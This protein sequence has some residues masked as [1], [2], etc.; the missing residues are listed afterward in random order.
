MK[1]GLVRSGVFE[2]WRIINMSIDKRGT[3]EK[4]TL[5]SLTGSEIFGYTRL[6]CHELGEHLIL[7]PHSFSFS[8]SKIHSHQR[9]SRNW[10]HLV[11][12]ILSS[13][14][15]AIC[16]NSK[17]DDE[18]VGVRREHVLTRNHWRSVEHSNFGFYSLCFVVLRIGLDDFVEKI[19]TGSG[20][21]RILIIIAQR[22]IECV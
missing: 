12:V 18:E 6:E 15:A 13:N 20:I 19:A 10:W 8:V 17:L 21:K 9:R 4:L 16:W 3:Q 22:I 1:V 14:A 2:G 11:K 5:T 7:G